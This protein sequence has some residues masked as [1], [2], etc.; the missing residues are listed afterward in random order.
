MPEILNPSTSLSPLSML[1]RCER[2]ILFVCSFCFRSYQWHQRYPISHPT[3]SI[4]R[5]HGTADGGVD[6]GSRRTCRLKLYV[7]GTIAGNLTEQKKAT[8]VPFVS[9]HDSPHAGPDDRLITGILFPSILLDFLA[10]GKTTRYP[11]SPGY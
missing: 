2:F 10:D 9:N 11:D 3:F 6:G 4:V 8:A 5:M 7:D 1:W